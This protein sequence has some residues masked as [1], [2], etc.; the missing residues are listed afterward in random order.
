VRIGFLMKNGIRVFTFVVA[1]ALTGVVLSAAPGQAQT[2][3][4]V[5]AF[6]FG[7]W[8]GESWH[9]GR[10]IDR[11]AAPYDSR[12]AGAVGRH[13]DQAKSVGIDA[14]IMSWFGPKDN[15]LTQ[16]VFGILLDQAG[17]RGFKAGA[18]VDMHEAGYNNSIEEVRT[19]LAHL[20]GDR[21]H[22]PAYLRYDGKPVIYFW[23]QG[24]F[25]VAQWREIRNQV[26]PD[27]NTIWVMEGSNTSYLAVFDGLYLFNTVW[28]NNPAATASTWQTRTQQAGGWF[29]TPTVL[30]GWQDVT[31][32]ANPTATRDRTDGQYLSRSWIGAASS[33]ANVILITSWNEYF[34]NSH[35][36]PSERHGTQALDILRPLIAEWKS[37]G[38]GMSTSSGGAPSAAGVTYTVHYNLRLRDNPGESAH[39]LATIQHSIVLVVSGRS[40]DNG[41]IRVTY[42][43]QAGYGR[44]SAPIDSVPIAP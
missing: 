38:A 8:T 20:I 17:A 42:N 19:S 28:S 31:G 27:H 39:V 26:D 9:D 15:N 24:R 3:R 21:V 11:P 4:Q 5:Y 34:E 30:P 18:A 29:Y 23:S 33:G 40:A 25:S 22:H 1:L 6:Y 13:I 41:W 2:G 43:G 12:D 14:F 16:Q 7:W 35:I 36:E 32:R 10:L 44:L 37:G